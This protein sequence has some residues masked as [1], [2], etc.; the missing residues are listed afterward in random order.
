M[1]GGAVGKLELFFPKLPLR[2]PNGFFPLF[3][4]SLDRLLVDFAPQVVSGGTLI[5]REFLFAGRY[6]G[7]PPGF[8]FWAWSGPWDTSVHGYLQLLFQFSGCR[9][10]SLF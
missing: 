7:C 10:G 5:G 8:R 6:L 1:Y 2:L 4:G 3:C 9:E